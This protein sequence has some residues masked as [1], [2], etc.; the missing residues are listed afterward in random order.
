MSEW[1]GKPVKK[2][3]VYMDVPTAILESRGGEV[4]NY[5]LGVTPDWL[6]VSIPLF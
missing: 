6:A 2:A 4:H 3:L 1:E 5:G